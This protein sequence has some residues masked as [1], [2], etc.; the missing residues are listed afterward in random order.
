MAEKDLADIRD[1]VNKGWVLGSDRFKKQ[2]E[3]KT[4]LKVSPA[5]RGGD[6]K[7]EAYKKNK[8]Y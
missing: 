4:G 6:R 3:E 7:S 5:K 2:I 8:S 1:S